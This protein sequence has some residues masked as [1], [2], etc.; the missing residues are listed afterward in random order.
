[1]SDAAASALTTPDSGGRATPQPPTVL[2]HPIIAQL[3]EII[4]RLCQLE[5]TVGTAPV[6]TLDSGGTATSVSAPARLATPAKKKKGVDSN[7]EPSVF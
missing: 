3:T 7:I 2:P 5:V 6:T 4:Q 1:M